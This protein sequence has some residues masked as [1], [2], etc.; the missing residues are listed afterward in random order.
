MVHE[1]EF[2]VSVLLVEWS[3]VT[4]YEL[5]EYEE[6]LRSSVYKL[7][8]KYRAVELWE[9]VVRESFVDYW[10]WKGFGSLAM[11]SFVSTLKGQVAECEYMISK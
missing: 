4:K 1:R 3:M 11:P 8:S 10:V 9:C 2:R 5:L 6:Y 7:Q